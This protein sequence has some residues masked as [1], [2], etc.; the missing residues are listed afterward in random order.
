[1]NTLLCVQMLWVLCSQS[2]IGCRTFTFALSSL[3]QL[4]EFS[5]I[6]SEMH[7]LGFYARRIF[8]FCQNGRSTQACARAM[9]RLSRMRRRSIL[10]PLP[11]SLPKYSCLTLLAAITLSKLIAA[12]LTASAFPVIISLCLN[13]MISLK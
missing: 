9:Y 8:G 3:W 1:M 6:H 10:M 2:E 13:R 7:Q 5:S 12:R 4:D 11:L